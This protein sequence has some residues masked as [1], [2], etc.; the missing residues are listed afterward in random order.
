[1][2]VYEHTYR[3][4]TG[5]LTPPRS[6]IM[7]LARY[8]M[9]EAWSSKITIA[10]FVLCLLP[11]L[12]FLVGIY[13]SNNPLAQMA[14]MRGSRM[15]AIDASYFLKILTTQS[16][17]ALILCSWVAPRLVSF[18]LS[19]N[20]LPIVLSHP[21]SRIGYVAGKFIALFSAMSIVT[22]IPA[23]LLFAF[24]CYSA[25]QPWFFSNLRIAF[26]VLAGSI[27]WLCFLSLL[28]LA[29]S[30]WVKWRVV[31]TGAI[32][33][34]LF[35]P[36]GIGAVVSAVLRTPWG[37]LL[38]MP[39]LISTLWERLLGAGNA[40]MLGGFGPIPTPAILLVLSLA[41]ALFIAMLNARIRAREVVK[42]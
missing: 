17:L 2:S 35:V 20:A 38:N 14:I 42:G 39:Y 40:H 28:G 10:L 31:A 36:A 4:Y 16:W 24:E 21:I 19:D 12:T 13:V 11:L 18:D 27:I 34:A 26:G 6:R 37:F 15:L 30:A 41:C 32:F 5:P 29:I 7:V 25:P 9:A 3:P 1:M 8:G 33:A 23:L 22:W